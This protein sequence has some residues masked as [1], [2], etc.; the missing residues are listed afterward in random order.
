MNEKYVHKV[1]MYLL[2]TIQNLNEQDEEK[3]LTTET[4]AS[5]W[6]RS[7]RFICLFILFIV[8]T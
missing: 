3:T 2:S 6:T 4:K 1:G 5:G 8:I 7:G